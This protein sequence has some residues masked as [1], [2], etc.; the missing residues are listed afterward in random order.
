[1]P[2][3]THVRV[4]ARLGLGLRQLLQLR[5]LSLG[6]LGLH[7]LLH[8]G[9]RVSLG[10]SLRLGLRGGVLRLRLRLHGGVG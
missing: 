3:C 1:L 7:V 8:L 2:T 9:L 10:L 5:G 4:H 6:C